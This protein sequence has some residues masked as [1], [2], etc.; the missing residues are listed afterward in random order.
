[1][2]NFSAMLSLSYLKMKKSQALYINLDRQNMPTLSRHSGTSRGCITG[3]D[4]IRPMKK[5]AQA[6]F[7]AGFNL[8]TIAL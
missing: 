7:F 5:P 3:Q 1:M 4:T 6:G 2:I 8:K